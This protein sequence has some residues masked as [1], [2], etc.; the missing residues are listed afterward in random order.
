[1]LTGV[2]IC[3][4]FIKFLFLV[5]QLLEI[6]SSCS[7]YCVA[8]DM[9]LELDSFLALGMYKIASFQNCLVSGFP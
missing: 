8:L 1:M 7:W 3:L 5:I 2:N 6:L 9:L 4:E